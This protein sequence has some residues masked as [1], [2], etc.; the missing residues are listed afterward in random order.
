MTV[1]A[2]DNVTQWIWVYFYYFC[3]SL[4]FESLEKLMHIDVRQVEHCRYDYETNTKLTMA[5][6][7][8]ILNI[9]KEVELQLWS[10]R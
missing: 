9:N 1:M 7:H 2:P 5:A 6:I 8:T 3:G 4:S 10:N